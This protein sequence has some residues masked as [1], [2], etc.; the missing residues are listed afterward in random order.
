MQTWLHHLQHCQRGKHMTGIGPRLREE[1]ARLKLSQ[2]ALGTLGGV[3]TNA[4]GNYESGAR[5]P[6]ADYLLRIA[7][8]GVDIYYVLTGTRTHPGD[9]VPQALL[10]PAA[11]ANEE[12]LGR[13]THQLHR[14]LQV[15]ID[16][17]YQV[18]LLIESRAHDSGNESVKT[19]LDAFRSEAQA[20]AQ[21]SIRLIFETSKL[22]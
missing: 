11:P 3:E 21:S 17:L 15:L 12:H 22:T 2:S 7:E 9:P 13:V 18:N 1:R 6:K 20:L 19:V 14:N 5:S 16:A 8:S 10:A 4:Q